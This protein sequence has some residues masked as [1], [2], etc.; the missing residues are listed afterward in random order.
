MKELFV[1]AY[2]QSA[3]GKLGAVAVPEMIEAAVAGVC[4]EIDIEPSTIDVAS[5]GAAWSS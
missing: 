2:H 4:G 3:F 5:I 1:V